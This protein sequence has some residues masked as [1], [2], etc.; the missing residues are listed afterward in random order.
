MK[1][2][3]Y[4]TYLKGWYRTKKG[5]SLRIFGHQKDGAKKRGHKVNY[6]LEEFRLWIFSQ[7]NFN[8]LYENWIKSDFDRW[9][10]PSV[11]RVDSSKGYF[12]ENITL[13]KWRE[14][15]KKS[16]RD[17]AK[18]PIGS[19]KSGVTGVYYS[20]RNDTKKD[21]VSKIYTNKKLTEKRFVTFEEALAYRK[22]LEIMVYG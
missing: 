10:R 11:D 4:K 7:P 17:I 18:N 21:W 1:D 2:N 13:M 3:K 9:Q 20:K 16:H 8:A 19:N 14:N 22:E 6:T 5:L 15:W 12:F